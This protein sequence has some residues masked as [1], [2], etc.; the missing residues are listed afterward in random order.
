MQHLFYKK[1]TRITDVAKKIQRV[2]WDRK[3]KAAGQGSTNKERPAGRAFQKK[4]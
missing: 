3:D 1:A 4:S 2:G